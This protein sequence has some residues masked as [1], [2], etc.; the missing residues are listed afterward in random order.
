MT[1]Y[2]GLQFHKNG[3]PESEFTEA[4]FARAAE[5]SASYLFSVVFL[6]G[7]IDGDTIKNFGS[8]DITFHFMDLSK[9][10]KSLLNCFSGSVGMIDERRV[11]LE[12]LLIDLKRKNPNVNWDLVIEQLNKPK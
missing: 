1:D 5:I 10:M 7:L 6:I 4:D 3:K 9:L 12:K 8:D 11:N 2:F